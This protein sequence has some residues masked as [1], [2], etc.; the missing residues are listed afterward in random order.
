M[1]KVLLV[2]D[3]PL[4]ARMYK[5]VFAFEQLDLQ[6][7][8]NGKAGLELLKTYRP[9]I[10]LVDIMMPLM[11]G[12]EMLAKLKADP[13]LKD[14][15][16]IMLSNL[17][18]LRTAEDAVKNGALKYIVKSKYDPNKIAEMLKEILD[19]GPAANGPEAAR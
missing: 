7:A 14:I 12:V 5:R 17:S 11:N 2:E 9:E 19:G 18:D 1:H 8:E 3:D 10:M 15:P 4:M 6:I 16:V 13:Q